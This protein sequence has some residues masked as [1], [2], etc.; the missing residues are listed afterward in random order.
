ML[1]P[2]A[3]QYQAIMA[4]QELL[5]G[6]NKREIRWKLAKKNGEII[7]LSANSGV[8]INASGERYLT[9]A[10]CDEQ[11]LASTLQVSSAKPINTLRTEGQLATLLHHFPG[12]VYRCYNRPDWPMVFV[13]QG[14]KKLT[15]YLPE[16]FTQSKTNTYNSIIHPD[17][18]SRVWREIQKAVETRHIFNLFYR[19]R[20]KS[21]HEKWV[22]EQGH[23]IGDKSS[24]TI[25]IAGFISDITELKQTE[26]G[27]IQQQ[28]VMSSIFDAAS[29]GIGVAI[30]HI[31]YSANNSLCEMLGYSSEELH[32]RS[33]QTIFFSEQD[34]QG[35]T[36]IYET[37]KETLSIKREACLKSKNGAPLDVYMSIAPLD[38]NDF[39]KGVAF[40]VIDISKRKEAEAA[41]ESQK[42]TLSAIFK[43]TPAGIGLIRDCHFQQVNDRF[44]EMLGYDQSGLLASGMSRSLCQEFYQVI[45]E[46]MAVQIK[47]DGLGLHE[48]QFKRQDGS[49]ID[50]MLSAAQLDPQDATQ[51]FTFSAL[52][53]TERKKA[54]KKLKVVA[55]EFTAVLNNFPE[56]L[57]LID[58]ETYEIIF[59]NKKLIDTLGFDPV[60]HV[61]YTV[62]QDFFKPC[63]LC[64]Q[65]IKQI[66]EKGKVYTWEH[67]SEYYNK[68]FLI[69]EQLIGWPDG[70]DVRMKI[71][72][73]ISQQKA[74]ERKI[75]QQAELLDKA[76]DAISLRSL[77]GK[78]LY[79][80]KAA[81]LIFGWTREEILG[82]SAELIHAEEN[83]SAF[84]EALKTVVDTG[85]WIGEFETKTKDGGDLIIDSHWTLVNNAEG[86][87]TSI[88]SISTD[89]TLKKQIERQLLRTQR[90]EN[91]GMLAGGIA[92]DLNNI[93]S[94]I[95]LSIQY[96]KMKVQDPSISD[97]LDSVRQSAQRGADMVKQILLFSKGRESKRMPVKVH[98]LVKEIE[99]LIQDTFP[100]RISVA[101]HIPKTLHSINGDPTELHQVLL[102]LCVNAR[103]AMQDNGDLSITAEN[104]VFDTASPDIPPD[105]KPGTYIHISVADT[106][107]G[108]PKHL[109]DKIFDPFF[110][111]KEAGKGTGLGLFT[112]HG[113]VKKHNGFLTVQSMTGKGTT[114][115]LYFPADANLGH[116]AKKTMQSDFEAGHGET[117][118]IIE[119]EA[120]LRNIMTQILDA[121]GYKVY[122]AE[123]GACGTDLFVQHKHEID[124]IIVDLVMPV[125]DGVSTVYAIRHISP[126]LPIIVCSG[127]GTKVELA[128][129]LKISSFLNKP[130][131]TETL[132]K[133]ISSTLSEVQVEDR[134]VK[135]QK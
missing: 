74:A 122:V 4:I 59:A 95:L 93:L 6:H 132:L 29:I 5:T 91:I 57:Y 13:S 62:I 24:E 77:E 36:G 8:L 126:A 65:S 71:I 98:H 130:F 47:K 131:T 72:V 110:T 54:E 134:L 67:H 17:D 108:I 51:G 104:V 20:T 52:D 105:V 101:L 64:S 123:N 33:V 133:I 86:K 90:L 92:H 103:D 2:S 55:D 89:V 23:A 1:C 118:L 3:F 37:L 11:F 129:S 42:A 70:R 49:T 87:P 114:F 34:Y 56:I 107:T 48:T 84:K 9:L 135:V 12:M 119:D 68:D 43:S 83:I 109:L 46:E 28:A 41:L 26:S 58:I 79:W 7:S 128:S 66:T 112:V 78:I 15:G 82:K 120:P 45:N 50:V 99:R 69:S 97:I 35:E 100:K 111:T 81:E 80:N 18:Q 60:G 22:F 117:I 73:D 31:F 40:S 127:E 27:L 125:M 106:G 88:L 25:S 94:P 61:C 85:E 121:H 76:H 75:Q 115:H 44:C 21:G 63:D 113:I 53:I 30:N 39:S 124:A 102:N 38:S 19:I 14:S 16:E 116:Q 96:L 10:F 32:G